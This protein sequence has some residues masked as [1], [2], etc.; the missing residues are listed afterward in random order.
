MK[1]LH[2]L[3]SVGVGGYNSPEDVL[4]VQKALNQM[5]DKIGLSSPL[6]EDGLIGDNL[7]N[8]I[9]CQ[10]IGAFQTSILNYHR[11]DFRIDPNGKS[12]LMIN[13]LL[14]E[15]EKQQA[16]YYFPEVEPLRGLTD[17]DY[18]MAA[19]AL[20]CDVA[21]I[22]AVSEVES[23]GNGYFASGRPVILFEAHQFSRLTNHQF[24]ETHPDISSRTWNRALYL[25]AEKEYERLEKALQLDR[26]AAL[27]SASYGRYQIMGF[28]YK[29]AG[30]NDVETFV[31][32]MFIAERNHLMAFVHF[33]KANKQLSNSIQQQDWALFAKN[34]NG[35]SYAINHYD[36]KLQNSYQK[37]LA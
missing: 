25:K 17:A 15:S 24:D 13:T 7:P 19:Q 34:Y 23:S 10:A 35:P 32:D 8:S 5:I 20:N 9:T 26:S 11:P 21:A 33:I 12:H 18:Q 29:T 36:E 22:Q 3:S 28:N 6:P 1:E 37:H 16:S 2:L 4:N 14:N 30:Y 31:H 27:K